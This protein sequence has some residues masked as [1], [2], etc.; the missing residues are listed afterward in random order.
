LPH[1]TLKINNIYLSGTHIKI[2]DHGLLSLK[3]FMSI[4][5]GYCNKSIYTAPELLSGRCNKKII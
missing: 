3:K 4:T 5:Q 2:A 1:G